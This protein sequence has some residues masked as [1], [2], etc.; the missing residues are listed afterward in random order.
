MH[1]EKKKR[2]PRIPKT[3]EEVAELVLLK[4]IRESKKLERFKKSVFYR[5]GNVFNIIC[6]FI[7][8]E[9]IICFFG[10]CNYETHYS[11]NMITEYGEPGKNGDQIVTQVKIVGV[12]NEKYTLNVYDFIERPKPFSAYT[13][14]R[15]FLLQKEIKVVLEVSDKTF[16]ISRVSPILFLSFFVSFLSWTLFSYNLNQNPYSLAAITI[17]NALTMVAFLS[18]WRKIN[19]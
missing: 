19:D 11:R 8:C 18:I 16:G 14:G 15:D 12:N 6:F 4:K 3:P 9:L 5:C 10:P 2:P 17:I 1:G 7:Y 13:L